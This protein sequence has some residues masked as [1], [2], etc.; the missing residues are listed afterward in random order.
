MKVKY[1]ALIAGLFAIITAGCG[2]APASSPAGKTLD[3]TVE[4][5]AQNIDAKLE[6]GTKVAVLSFNSTSDSLSEY[7]LG[8]LTDYL[9]NSGKLIVLDRN[10]LD[11]VRAELNFNLTDEVADNS[12]QEAGRMLGAKY[13]VTGSYQEDVSRIRIKTI[14]VESAGIAASSSADVV[15][16]S[17]MQRLLASKATPVTPVAP[18]PTVA[19]ATPVTPPLVAAAPPVVT[20]PPAAGPQSGTYRFYPR[21]RANQG[22]VDKDIYVDRIIIRNNYLTVYLVDTSV[23]K[24]NRNRPENNWGGN[25]QR[26]TVLKDLNSSLIWN[27]AN[28]G[29]DSD[30]NGFY[31]T[32]FKVTV[33]RFSLANNNPYPPIIF[34]E[35]VLVN[36]N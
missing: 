25:T 13:I 33:T 4:E 7:V 16:D 15:S 29:E 24:A 31:I 20:P 34:D 28:M 14:V 6:A 18:P 23:G 10:D 17:K 3:Q 11:A 19:A 36:P 9:V 30:T 21:L 5:A 22:G 32:F 27:V 1:M 12:A 8:E 2:S 35:I 26:S